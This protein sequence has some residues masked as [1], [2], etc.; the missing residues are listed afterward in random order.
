MERLLWPVLETMQI[1]LHRIVFV[2]LRALT[3]ISSALYQGEGLNVP[4]MFMPTQLIAPL[5]RRHGAHIGSAVRFLAPVTIHNAAPKPHPFYYNL[6]VGNNC[7]L[8]RQLF[9]DLQDKVVIED[10]VTV[11]H[12]VT[13]LTHTDAGESPLKD[14]LLPSSQA[15][16]ILRRGS[17]IGAGAMILA[18]VEIGECAIVG[19][20]AVVAKNVPPC[21]TVA[22]VPARM[23]RRPALG[24]GDVKSALLETEVKQS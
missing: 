3:S 21:T 11:S 8:G 20:G 5:F 13:I 15:P 10:N 19:A 24:E 9:L 6:A 17:Y 2:L 16:V 14:G 18:G 12:R 23:I 7:Y 22:G 4:L 1:M